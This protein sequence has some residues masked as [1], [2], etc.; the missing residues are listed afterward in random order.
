MDVRYSFS[1]I[2][3]YILILGRIDEVLVL[4]DIE[5]LFEIFLGFILC[6]WQVVVTTFDI[7]MNQEV[8]ASE[9]THWP[10]VDDAVFPLLII[11]QIGGSEVL[12]G[13]DGTIV[14]ARLL[15]RHLHADVECGYLPGEFL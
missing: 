15:I 13:M 6:H 11:A 2:Y 4:D 12:D 1:H 10:P 3:I 8:I 7:R 5:H 9:A 14:Q